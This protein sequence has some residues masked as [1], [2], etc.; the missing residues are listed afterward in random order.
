M[1]SAQRQIIAVPEYATWEILDMALR[2]RVTSLIGWT[3][4]GDI[5][6]SMRDAFGEEPKMTRDYTWAW[7]Q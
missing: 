3:V 5:I 2:N 4:C 1:R 6:T 7:S